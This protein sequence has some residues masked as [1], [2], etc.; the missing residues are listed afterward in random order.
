MKGTECSVWEIP[1]VTSPG[2]GREGTWAV[3]LLTAKAQRIPEAQG[4]NPFSSGV[5]PEMLES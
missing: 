1:A 3:F 2:G 5:A 4:S